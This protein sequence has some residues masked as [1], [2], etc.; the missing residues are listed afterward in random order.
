MY[1]RNTSERGSAAVIHK[2]FAPRITTSEEVRARVI[3]SEKNSTEDY[4]A[5]GRVSFI[6][7]TSR[8]VAEV[9]K[10]ERVTGLLRVVRAYDAA[11]LIIGEMQWGRQA[12]NHRQLNR[13]MHGGAKELARRVGSDATMVHSDFVSGR[14]LRKQQA[15]LG[16][17]GPFFDIYEAE[18]VPILFEA[19]KQLR[20]ATN[21]TPQEAENDY[22]VFI[23][24]DRTDL[25]MDKIAMLLTVREPD[26]KYWSRNFVDALMPGI[27][28]F[29][30]ERIADASVSAAYSAA[31][32]AMQ[33]NLQ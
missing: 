19:A 1:R 16:K 4:G 24:T 23:D 2:T 12:G 7:F 22:T 5:L 27:D 8:Q 3:S 15:A 30:R 21:G 25:T 33:Q 29:Q 28:Q 14:D 9:V 17:L 11:G 26:G 18:H 13:A 10:T 6:N 20:E 32:L 31:S